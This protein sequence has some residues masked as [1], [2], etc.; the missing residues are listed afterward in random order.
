MAKAGGRSAKTAPFWTRAWWARE[1]SATKRA[2]REPMWRVTIGPYRALRFRR[3][4]SSSENDLRS[5]KKLPIT[6]MVRGPGG[7]LGL[8]TVGMKRLRMGLRR[9]EM[10]RVMTIRSQVSMVNNEQ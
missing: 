10:Q 7:S 6:G 5:H 1:R 8:E 4:G 3:T 9:K 2:G